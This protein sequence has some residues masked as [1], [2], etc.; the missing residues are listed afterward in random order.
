[1]GNELNIPGDSPTIVPNLNASNRPLPRPISA[2]IFSQQPSL[3]AEQQVKF[4]GDKQLVKVSIAKKDL[5]IT[6]G[7]VVT[8]VAAGAEHKLYDK[9]GALVKPAF[10]NATQTNYEFKL[11]TVAAVNLFLEVSRPAAS[12]VTSA[13]LFVT[14]TLFVTHPAFTPVLIG[15]NIAIDRKDIWIALLRFVDNTRPIER[16]FI[17]DLPDNEPTVKEVQS[18]LRAIKMEHVLDKVPFDV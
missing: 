13:S 16:L 17:C 12:P 5:L 8:L 3:D 4:P 15:G 2:S 7:E 14:L 11:D 1:M 6:D 9:L 18:E 10:H